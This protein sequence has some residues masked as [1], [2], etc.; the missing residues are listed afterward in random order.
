MRRIAHTAM[1]LLET[2]ADPVLSKMNQ[3]AI[4]WKAPVCQ[5]LKENFK[6]FERKETNV[7]TSYQPDE[8][9][10]DNDVALLEKAFEG[11][12]QGNINTLRLGFH[13]GM[14]GLLP[15]SRRQ[16]ILQSRT[17]HIFVR[18]GDVIQ[19]HPDMRKAENGMPF[20]VYGP[21]SDAA[22][23]LAARRLLAI[24]KKEGPWLDLIINSN[25][26]ASS[27]FI[28]F[29]NATKV[30]INC[31][32]H[33]FRTMFN[34][35]IMEDYSKDEDAAKAY[36]KMSLASMLQAL[37]SAMNTS[38]ATL[39]KNYMQTDVF[40]SARKTLPFIALR[41][42]GRGEE[43]KGENEDNTAKR[44]A[45]E[46]LQDME[47]QRGE[48]VERKRMKLVKDM[49]L[50]RHWDTQLRMLQEDRRAHA[51]SRGDVGMGMVPS[52]S[53]S[54]GMGMMP[55]YS[56]GMAFGGV[57]MMPGYPGGTAFGGVGMMPY[58]GGMAFGGVGMM[59]GFHGGMAFGGVGVMPGYSG[60]MAFGGVGM[61]P[62]YGDASMGGDYQ[63]CRG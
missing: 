9:L 51:S 34:S 37:G 27:K 7:C 48:G 42:T 3:N 47:K 6:K 15:P 14:L 60:G 40:N 61:M 53:G 38:P 28:K 35:C 32:S 21:L 39:L 30:G 29:M 17:S 46:E 36:Y 59:P 63:Y 58:P 16:D 62:A 31:S 1:D 18:G 20:M 43:E 57:G 45:T 55:G 33:P 22:L 23:V 2:T 4:G 10:S 13:Y 54:M 24:A 26:Q 11:I 19:V 50:M 41:L 12:T 5:L 52:Y 49:K 25:T 56:G 8:D 44:K